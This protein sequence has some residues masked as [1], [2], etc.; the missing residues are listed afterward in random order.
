MRG[1][2]ATLALTLM[3]TPQLATA[4]RGDRYRYYDEPPAVDMDDEIFASYNV[5]YDGTFIFVR[6][7]YTPSRTGYGGGGG[8]FGGIN[9][10]WDHDYPRAEENFMKIVGELT[11]IDANTRGHNILSVGDPEIMKHPLGFIVEAGWMTLTD[12][13]ADN[14]RN[15]L[16]KGGFLIFD[17]FAGYAFDNFYEQL[18]R[19][20][21]GSRLVELDAR[22][23]IFHSF[24][25]IDSL[26]GF[27]HPY[28]G[29]P[30]I[31]LGAHEDNDPEK[32]LLL[33]A[34]YNN[35]V[36]ESWEFSD[37]GFIPIEI[38]NVAY[39]LGVNYV[40]YAMTH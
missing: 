1:Y 20:L 28:R 34:N 36:M 35:D 18:Q 22:H 39:K 11:A 38:S 4:Q 12:E 27:Y 24:F 2:T 17:D 15:F 5:P 8:F 21:P 19:I 13:E 3:L 23:P 37:T 32:R 14:L 40:T 10:Q 6:L 29:M 26:D 25:D 16:L 7:R 31:F 33:V 30:S 9:F